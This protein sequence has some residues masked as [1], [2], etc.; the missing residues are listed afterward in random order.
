MHWLN[1]Q[2]KEIKQRDDPEFWK[3]VSNTIAGL[4]HQYT[5]LTDEMRGLIDALAL[6]NCL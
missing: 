6:E 4:A 3:C 5:E 2:T 1:R